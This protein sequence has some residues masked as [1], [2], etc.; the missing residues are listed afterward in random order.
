MNVELS[1]LKIGQ[2]R[3]LT[4]EEMADINS[5]VAS[6]TKVA[7]TTEDTARKAIVVNEEPKTNMSK[8]NKIYHNKDVKKKKSETRLSLKP[9]K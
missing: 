7:L 2:W 4:R 5:A 9:K 1:N 6:S 3:D 8:T